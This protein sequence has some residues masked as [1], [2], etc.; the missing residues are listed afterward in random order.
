[1]MRRALPHRTVKP[2]DFDVDPLAFNVQNGTLRFFTTPDL[3]DPDD[4]RM[5]PRLKWDVRL[6]EH[7]RDDLISK[8][9]PVLYDADAVCPEWDRFLERVQP[10]PEMRTIP[11]HLPR[12]R[13]DRPH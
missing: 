7:N 2:E 9:A 11:A 4:T 6:D 12:L 1:M 3:D 5:E 13:A 8:V 10:K